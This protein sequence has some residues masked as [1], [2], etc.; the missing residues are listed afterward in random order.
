MKR[1]HAFLLQILLLFAAT[2]SALRSA[3]F[4]DSLKLAVSHVVVVG[5]V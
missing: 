4:A 5:T 3:I 1:E 2:T